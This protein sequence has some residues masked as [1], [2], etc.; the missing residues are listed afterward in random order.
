MMANGNG[1]IELAG[2]TLTGNRHVCGFFNSLDEEYDVLLDFI[3]DGLNRGERA[4]HVIDP[5][6]YADH[7]QRLETAGI[8]T[9]A[10]ID[11]G[12]LA[13]MVWDDVYLPNDRFDQDAMLAL[14]EKILSD[15][16]AQGYPVTRLIAQMEWITR[17]LPGVEHYNEYEARLNHVLPKYDDPV[18]CAYDVRKFGAD[19]ILDVLRTHPIVIIGRVLQVNPFYVPPDQFVAE[20]RARRP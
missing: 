11:S 2:V 19:A 1:S 18:I 12:Q 17:A 16:S 10:A 5:A 14:I 8:N 4:V 13:V 9:Q 3:V 6:R 15:G 20:V 7:R